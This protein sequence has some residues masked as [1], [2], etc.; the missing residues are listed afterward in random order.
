M[1]I[2]GNTITT[3]ETNAVGSAAN[4][5][6]V[7]KGDTISGISQKYGIS[8]A[9]LLEANPG[10]TKPDQ[11][12]IGQ[13]INIPVEPKPV[14]QTPPEV[15][16]DPQPTKLDTLATHINEATHKANTS[17]SFVNE[18]IKKPVSYGTKILNASSTVIKDYYASSSALGASLPVAVTA[19]AIGKACDVLT[20][21]TTGFTVAE[22]ATS[23]N[24]TKDQ[25]IIESSRVI[26]ATTGGLVVSKIGAKA[27]CVLG[28]K[29]GAAIGTC[30]APGPGTAIGAFVGGAAGAIGGYVVGNWSGKN[31]GRFL[32]DKIGKTIA[33][34]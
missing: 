13:K 15:V 8:N 9:R 18:N 23:K 29:L 14:V 16:I 6:I 25:K 5:Y 24:K 4:A 22:I 26:C 7:K 33:G 27:G 1:Q 17:L 30:I 12:K 21:V 10:I 2:S 19:K 32:G 20:V 31:F 34:H 28:V 3:K 11:I